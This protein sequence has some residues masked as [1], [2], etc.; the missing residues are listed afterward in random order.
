MKYFVYE[1]WQA[2]LHKAVTHVDICGFCNSGQGLARGY[3][4]NHARWHGPFD[5]L[6]AAQRC[7]ANL[8]GVVARHSHRCVQ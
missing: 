1:N 7:S 8:P 4:P 2:G 5:S 3:D 6:A